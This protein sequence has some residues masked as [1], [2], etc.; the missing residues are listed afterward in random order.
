[1]T[2]IYKDRTLID[3]SYYKDMAL[4][5]VYFFKSNKAYKYLLIKYTKELLK[6]SRKQNKYFL[7]VTLH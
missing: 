7:H 1:M 3:Y 4:I 2:R 5:S 6:T